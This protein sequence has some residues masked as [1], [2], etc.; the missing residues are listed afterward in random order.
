MKKFTT[1][2]GN[3]DGTFKTSNPDDLQHYWVEL[4]R[5]IHDPDNPAVKPRTDKMIQCFR[6]G[7]WTQMMNS[8]RE[9]LKMREAGKRGESYFHKPSAPAINWLTASGWHEFTLLH[10]PSLPVD[11]EQLKVD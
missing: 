5:T 2:R 11:L 3:L 7:E 10:D 1:Y 4:K 6:P 9:W 8:Y